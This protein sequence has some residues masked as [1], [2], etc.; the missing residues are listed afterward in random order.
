M[1]VEAAPR[2]VAVLR[3]APP[4]RAPLLHPEYLK[5]QLLFDALGAGAVQKATAPRR[6][7]NF[8]NW[9]QL[10][11]FVKTGPTA[12]EGLTLEKSQ[13]FIFFFAFLIS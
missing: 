2:L 6:D 11:F 7:A 13:F 12:A 1:R 3:D 8:R 5:N 9:E 4:A 10:L